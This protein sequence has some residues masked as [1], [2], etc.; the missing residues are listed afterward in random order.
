MLLLLI[1]EQI[2]Y[3]KTIQAQSYINNFS[4]L[5]IVNYAIQFKPDV[6]YLLVNYKHLKKIIK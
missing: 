1:N 5:F 3:I 4:I 2:A 6:I